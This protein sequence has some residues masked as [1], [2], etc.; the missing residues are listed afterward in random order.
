[1]SSIEVNALLDQA[2]AERG[3][4]ANPKEAA[5]VGYEVGCRERIA[6]LE[7]ENAELR[8]ALGDAATSLGTIHRLAGR[9]TYGNPPIETYMDDFVRVRAYAKSRSDVA[10]AA[11]KETP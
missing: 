3:W 6:A 9:D 2:L 1:M 10:R 5:R 11:L 7:A 4:P 8:A